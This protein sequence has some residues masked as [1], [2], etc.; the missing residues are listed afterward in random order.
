MERSA[1]HPRGHSWGVNQWL[2]SHL[3]DPGQN[4]TVFLAVQVPFRVNA[5]RLNVRSTSL[6]SFS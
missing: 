4:T 1:S 2:W 3:V 6:G 5:K